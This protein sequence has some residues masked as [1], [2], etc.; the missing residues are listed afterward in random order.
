MKTK[1]KERL[2]LTEEEVREKASELL[3]LDKIEL[4]IMILFLQQRI[5]KAK[6]V[7]FEYGQID[8]DHHKAWVIDQ[9]LRE[10]LKEDYKKF[11]EAYEEPDEDGDWCE[12]D[13]GI[14]P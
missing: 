14:V 8:G 12:W 3:K 10:L 4:I 13:T 6:D 1:F 9:M 2:Y 5:D 7:A 11:I